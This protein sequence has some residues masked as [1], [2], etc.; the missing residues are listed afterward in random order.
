[1]LPLHMHNALKATILALQHTIY[2]TI[3]KTE[4]TV[5]FVFVP[6][7]V[8]HCSPAPL[9]QAQD[10]CGQRRL[11]ALRKGRYG[12]F[13]MCMDACQNERFLEQGI[14]VPEDISPAIPDCFFTNGTGSSAQHQSRPDAAFVCGLPGR[15]AHLD[16]SKIPPQDKDIH[17]VLF[18]ILP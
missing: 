6:A 1:M 4:A 12:S 16:P 3:L 9:L 18:L 8:P 13:L 7:S 14:E 5:S 2:S 17:L 15:S 10:G 11:K